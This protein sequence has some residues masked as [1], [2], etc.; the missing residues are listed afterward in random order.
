MVHT[1][2]CIADVGESSLS[3][4]RYITMPYITNSKELNE[5]DELIVQHDVKIRQYNKDKKGNHII[6]K[7]THSVRIGYLGR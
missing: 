3:S 7:R 1:S 2:M 4:T 6:E 5:G